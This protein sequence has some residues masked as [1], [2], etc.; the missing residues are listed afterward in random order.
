MLVGTTSVETSERLSDLL[1]RKDVQ[2][3]V[4]NAKQHER[5][6]AIVAEAGQPGA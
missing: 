3:E 2:H 1:T 6:A 5:E 4:L